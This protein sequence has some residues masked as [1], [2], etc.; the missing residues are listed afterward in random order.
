MVPETR[1]VGCGFVALRCPACRGTNM[2]HNQ[3]DVFVRQEGASDGM[4]VDVFTKDL[5]SDVPAP[6]DLIK[7][8]GNMFG[9][10]SERRGGVS[11]YF[12]CED[13][14]TRSVLRFAQHKGE[15]HVD[16]HTGM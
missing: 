5:P 9:N 11:I 1:E 12:W 7:V 10:P 2:H 3:V 16:I 14:R 4:R 13:C 15:T 6:E 8:S